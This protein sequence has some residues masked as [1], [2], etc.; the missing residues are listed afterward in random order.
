MKYAV[1]VEGKAELLFV[2]D[3]LAKYSNY[4]PMVVG[5]RCINL[6]DDSFEYVQFPMQGDV[7]TSRDFYQIVNVNNDGLVISKLRKDIPNLVKQG[8]EIIVGLRDVFSADYK[9]LCTHQQVNMELISEMHEVQSGQLNVVEGADVR[10]HYAIMEYETWM[11]ALMGNY[12]SSKGC[13]FAKILE[14]IGIDPDSDFEQEIYHP[15]NKVQDVYKAVNERY[16]KHE[17]DHLAFLASVAV[18]DYE[19]LR[20]SGRCASFKHFIDS[21]LLN[22]N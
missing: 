19:K 8:Y 14:K 13:D 17:S 9:L 2:A 21:L 11:M 1:Y 16:G 22:N 15:Y 10:L 12:V 5:F 7:E 3:V 18:A 6:N 4:D 20:H